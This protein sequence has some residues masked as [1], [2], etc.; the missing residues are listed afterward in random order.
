MET[1]KLGLK[2]I[3]IPLAALG[4]MFCLS[5]YSGSETWFYT[6]MCLIYFVLPVYVL[7]VIIGLSVKHFKDKK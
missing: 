7:A 5:S 3:L 2:L 1:L 4:V 6:V